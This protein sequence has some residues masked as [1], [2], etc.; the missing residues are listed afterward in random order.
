MVSLARRATSSKPYPS[1]LGLGLHSKQSA[2]ANI[3]T[4]NMPTNGINAAQ[5]RSPT[6]KELDPCSTTNHIHI[7]K[8]L[9]YHKNERKANIDFVHYRGIHGWML[10][11]CFSLQRKK[12]IRLYKNSTFCV[13][14]VTSLFSLVVCTFDWTE[15]KKMID[16]RI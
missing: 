12:D 4:S 1:F 7:I 8:A 5:M 16:R 11:A 3:K 14:S 10:K 9:I 13:G 15:M 6:V 2:I